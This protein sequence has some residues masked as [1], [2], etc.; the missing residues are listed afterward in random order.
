MQAPYDTRLESGS[1]A[2][3][4]PTTGGRGNN[5]RSSYGTQSSLLCSVPVG[6]VVQIVGGPQY[7]QGMIWWEVFI[8]FGCGDKRDVT[9]WTSEGTIQERWL[10]PIPVL[11]VV[12]AN[13]RAPL[14][15]RLA[16]GERAHVQDPTGRNLGN[17]V[18]K[19]P[20]LGGE[21]IGEIPVDTTLRVLQ[22]P[23]CRDGMAWWKIYTE[24]KPAL[25][26]W[27][28]EGKP[29]EGF[30]LAPIDVRLDRPHPVSAGDEQSAFLGDIAVDPPENVSWSFSP[31][32]MALTVSFSDMTVGMIG[33]STNHRS[34]SVSFELPVNSRTTEI[35]V[36]LNAI[37]YVWSNRN[38]QGIITIR[39]AGR[40][41][42]LIWPKG[43]DR[44]FILSL[45]R[46]IRAVPSF[47]TKISLE[48]KPIS[49]QGEAM[50]AIDMIEM[51]LQQSD[52]SPAQ[53][54]G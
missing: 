14:G 46:K 31:D 1:L 6:H 37:G 50:M 44:S 35:P 20:G 12:Q 8:P 45:T 28:S 22:G 54:R 34:R 38:A 24:G 5:I 36:K 32:G 23:V 7:V 33:G 4:G 53:P 13:C 16:M 10:R 21:E 30:Y 43:S 27:T 52:V 49:A 18:R 25:R 39:Q 47:L 26:G 3:V 2:Y 29:G 15:T 40:Q 51:E 41:K 11:P 9:G 48:V 17:N 42:R 19:A